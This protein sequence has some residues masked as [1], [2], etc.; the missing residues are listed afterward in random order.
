MA[1]SMWAR[2]EVHYRGVPNENRDDVP[3]PAYSAWRAEQESSTVT[4]L[5]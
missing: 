4:S 2:H 3:I 5:G 1:E